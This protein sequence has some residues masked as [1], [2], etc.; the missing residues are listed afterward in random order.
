M[1]GRALFHS[2]DSATRRAAPICDHRLC[3]VYVG[4]ANLRISQACR[5]DKPQRSYFLFMEQMNR[6]ARKR[7]LF[8]LAR[9]EHFCD[10][11]SEFGT[12]KGG[13][14]RPV[15]QV[16]YYRAI[17][18]EGLV[19]NWFFRPRDS[20]GTDQYA[21]IM[22]RT[23][24]LVALAISSFL[25]EFALAGGKPSSSNPTVTVSCTDCTTDQ[26]LIITGTGFKSRSRIQIDIDGPVTYSVTTT[27]DSNGNIALDF[28][29]TL[30]Y[31]PGGYVVYA[32]VVSGKGAT[33][34]ATSELF[35]VE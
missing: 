23:L 35:T 29:T 11:C 14:L 7:P 1:N 24:L 4:V 31:N 9:L 2:W 32:S 5:S 28:G 15:T 26:S 20:H 10:F 27:A 25:G 13:D 12:A 34:A 3:R 18:T 17:C 22:K 8:A 6:N 33:L 21:S 16:Q 19:R 30:C